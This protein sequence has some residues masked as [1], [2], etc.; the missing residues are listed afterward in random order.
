MMKSAILVVTAMLFVQ[1]SDARSQE[2]LEFE[3]VS[4]W[5]PGDSSR[6][7]CAEGV[8]ARL[9][10]Q[11]SFSDKQMNVIVQFSN[12]G[13]AKW[14]GGMRLS[15]RYP[16]RTH[17]SITVSSSRSSTW[18]EIMPKGIRTMY[19]LVRRNKNPGGC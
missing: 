4:G 15:N 1:A 14:C 16:E 10:F 19:L 2:V 13:A 3:N 12:N 18:N 6:I 11:S 8:C 17:N 5:Q 7:L 9:Y